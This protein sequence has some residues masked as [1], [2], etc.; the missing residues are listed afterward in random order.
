MINEMQRVRANCTFVRDVTAINAIIIGSKC[1][2]D[3]SAIPKE[4]ATTK[5]ILVK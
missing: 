5:I 1:K 4:N 3:T 2:T